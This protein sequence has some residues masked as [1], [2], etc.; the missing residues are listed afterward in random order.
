MTGE[1][2]AYLYDET[3]YSHLSPE[4][5]YRLVYNLYIVGCEVVVSYAHLSGMALE[6]FRAAGI[7]AELM[8]DYGAVLRE[9]TIDW[10]GTQR[11]L[12]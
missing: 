7:Q 5:R 11:K 8:N 12:N 2:P 4:Q 9:P 3:F 6:I 10:Y 1:P